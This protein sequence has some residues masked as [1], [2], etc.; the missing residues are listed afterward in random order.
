MKFVFFVIFLSIKTCFCDLE[1]TNIEIIPDGDFIK[2]DLKGIE[3]MH[4]S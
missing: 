1:Y 2:N 3:S 4:L